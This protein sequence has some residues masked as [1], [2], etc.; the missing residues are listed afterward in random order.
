MTRSWILVS[1]L[2]L[3]ALA[4]GPVLRAD[5]EVPP[6]RVVALGE[7]GTIVGTCFLDRAVEPPAPPA[8]PPEKGCP[9]AAVDGTRERLLARGTLLADCL[10]SV[11]GIAAGKDWP[12]ALRG[13][14]RFAQVALRG[15]RYEP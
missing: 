6:Y 10:V 3:L 11:E 12:D 15:C 8:P 1:G 13:E 14:E 7:T 4:S 5:S 2:A 9:C